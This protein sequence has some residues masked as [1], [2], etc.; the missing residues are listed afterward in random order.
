MVAVNRCDKADNIVLKF[1]QVEIFKDWRSKNKMP[2][3][4]FSYRGDLVK[5]KAKNF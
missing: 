1:F 2:S 3:V 5:Q 4:I